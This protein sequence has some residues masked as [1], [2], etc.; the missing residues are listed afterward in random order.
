MDFVRAQPDGP[1]FYNPVRRFGG[2]EF[3]PPYRKVGDKLARWVREIGVDDP[4]VDPN[5]G[6]RH[7]FKTTARSAK[8]RMDHEVRE[9]MAGHATATVGEGYGKIPI[10]TMWEEVCRLPRFEVEPPTGNVPDSAAKRRRNAVRVATAERAKL[11][12][13]AA[14]AV[15]GATPAA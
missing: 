7:R 10:D 2:S 11:R 4:D 3:N 6:W 14:R 5:H 12:P 15:S 1:L 8:V 9:A 13:V